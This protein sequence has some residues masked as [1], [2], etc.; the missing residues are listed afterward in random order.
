MIKTVEGDKVV[1]D[2]R[3]AAVESRVL[4]EEQ[5]QGATFRVTTGD[6]Q[7]LLA[8]VYICRVAPVPT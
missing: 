3:H 8:K 7:E 6:Y 5:F 2:I 4:S 1:Y